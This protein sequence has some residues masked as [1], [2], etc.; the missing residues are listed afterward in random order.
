MKTKNLIPWCNLFSNASKYNI[1]IKQSRYRNL[2]LFSSG[3][4]F[5]LLLISYATYAYYFVLIIV[6]LTI[7]IVSV[8][9]TKQKGGQFTKLRFTLDE[10]GVCSFEDASENKLRSAVDRKEQFQL[11]TSSRFSFFGCWLCMAPLS[12][13]TLPETLPNA[14]NKRRKKKL[15]FIYRD[16]LSAEDFS[17]LSQVIGKLNKLS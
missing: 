14:I 13:L 16:S 4:L 10:E 15:L 6:V 7:T 17:R 2:L 3:V 8:F 5:S 9:I 12:N 11:L 1:C